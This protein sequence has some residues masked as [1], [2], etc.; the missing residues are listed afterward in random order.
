MQRFHMGGGLQ[1]NHGSCPNTQIVMVEP[2]RVK[3]AIN[4]VV[5]VTFQTEGGVCAPIMPSVQIWVALK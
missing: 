4:T 5:F 2:V 3:R 1:C